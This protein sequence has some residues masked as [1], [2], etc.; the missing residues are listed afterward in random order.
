MNVSHSLVRVRRVFASGFAAL[1]LSLGSVSA[2]TT[3]PGEIQGRV[4]NVSS[5]SYVNNARI[6]LNGSDLETFTNSSGEY[7]L[8]RVPAGVASLVV[9]YA[10]LSAQT[11]TVTVEAG[12]SVSRNFELDLERGRSAETDRAVMLDTFSVEAV[13]LNAQSLSLNER[14]NAA[15]IRN[16]VAVGEFGDS[17]DGNAAELL[18]YIPGISIEY[19][20]TVARGISVRGLPSSGT[21]VTID[22]GEVA[23]STS[24]GTGRNVE[25]DAFRLNNISRVEVTKVPTPDLP[26]NAQG[27]AV[28]IIS[29]SGFE[30]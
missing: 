10:G 16:V 23:N 20:S 28:Y 25:L 21:L 14:K 3:R 11:A 19:S 24:G 9:T 17:G 18:K 13:R 8:S 2:Q 5:G 27:G 12:K 6:A 7:R 29:K 4:F 26:A 30:R 15:N 22:G 1:A